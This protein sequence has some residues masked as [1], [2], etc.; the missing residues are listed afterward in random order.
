MDTG[1]TR[2]TSRFI[3]DGMLA[4]VSVVAILQALC[5]SGETGKLYLR[6]DDGELTLTFWAG[7]VIQAQE[8][9]QPPMREAAGIAQAVSRVLPRTEGRFAFFAQSASS[10]VP[11]TPS[12]LHTVEHILLAA[13]RL[14]QDQEQ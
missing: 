10:P 14:N 7:W 11:G 4:T 3:C 13:T 6:S 1:E 9:S 12:Q 5:L 2:D 8:R